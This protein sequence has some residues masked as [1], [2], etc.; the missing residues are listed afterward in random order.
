MA[1]KVYNYNAMR[2]ALIAA[3]NSGN[4]KAIN[5]DTVDAFGIQDAQFEEWK[6]DVKALYNAALEYH[7]LFRK[8][9]LTWTAEDTA[10]LTEIE[11]KKILPAWANLLHAGE[12]SK[13][14]RELR[15]LPNHDPMWVLRYIS[16][17]VTVAD[18]GSVDS[19]AGF[20]VFR[21]GIETE[22]GLRIAQN[23]MLTETD[24]DT[25][26]RYQSASRRV[27]ACNTMAEDLLKELET[28]KANLEKFADKGEEIKLVMTAVVKSVEEKISANN[29]SKKKAQATVD[30]LKNS[31]D[32]IVGKLNKAQQ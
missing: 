15:V 24:R 3:H 10:S 23:G 18:I 22:I 25:V 2:P 9:T 32:E 5:K 7:K 1:K 6:K 17:I 26:E 31:Y 29:E 12:K 8:P 21:K 14:S 4:K 27:S 20:D 28:A 16:K 13:E 30:E 19:D 11:Q